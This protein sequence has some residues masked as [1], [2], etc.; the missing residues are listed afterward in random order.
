M[1]NNIQRKPQFNF[2]AKQE[3]IDELRRVANILEIPAAQFAR[4]ALR[5][6]IAAIKSTDPRFSN[7]TAQV[8][9]N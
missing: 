2:E 1:K 6:K 3:L 5:E 8:Q 9:Q 7:L 4:E